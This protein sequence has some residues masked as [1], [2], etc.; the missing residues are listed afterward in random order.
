MLLLLSST[1]RRIS[2]FFKHTTFNYHF[3]IFLS[4]LYIIFAFNHT[5]FTTFN[6]QAVQVGFAYLVGLGWAIHTFIIA[7]ALEILSLRISVKF[8]IGAVFLVCSVCGFY[9]DSMGVVI[10]ED[11]IQSVFETHT[12]E[13]LEMIGFGLVGYVL[14]FGVL[15]CALLSV[16]KLTKPPLIRA[17]RQKIIALVLLGALVG[18]SY[19][20]YGKD[21][22]FVFKTQKSLSNMPNPIAPIRSLILYVQHSKERHFTHTLI[23]QD[24]HLSYNAQPQIVLFVIGESARSANFSLNG[25][26]RDTN[27]YTKYLDVI[28]FKEFYSCGV[29]TAISVPCMLTHYTRESYTHR[30][31]S[32][33]VNNIL[34]IAQS[35]GYDVWYLGNNGGKCV[36]GCDRNITHKILYPADSLDGAMLPDIERIIHDASRN[37]RPTFVVIHEYGSHGALY[38]NRYPLAFEIFTPVCRQ[39]ELSKCTLEEITNA[40]DNS[41]VYGDYVLSQMIESLQK[42]NMRSMLWYV[43][44]HGESLGELGQYMHGGLGYVLAPTHQK[45]IPSIMWFSPQWE[46]EPR[47]AR[48]NIEHEFS[49]DYVFHTLL[50]LLGIQTQAYD[51]Q[52]DILR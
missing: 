38:A 5:F 40:Y 37:K 45:H 50:H 49:H 13:A 1:F 32:L 8:V 15:P 29:I 46:Q 17:F 36:G 22:T 3:V 44:D 31:L 18:A 9:M 11:I 16:I 27:A 26:T 39:K 48:A 42:A 19:V 7:L 34:D 10:D 23:A 35:V 30:N 4:S 47:T 24:A 14:G 2:A 52:L 33:Y 41:L 12:N 6:A 21:I 25:Y 51:S 43:S 28:S 20:L